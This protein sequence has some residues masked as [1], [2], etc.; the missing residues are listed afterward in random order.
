MPVEVEELPPE[1]KPSGIGQTYVPRDRDAPAVVLKEDVQRT[2]AQARAYI[3]AQHR[4]RSAPT[5][6]R[7]PAVRVAADLPAADEDTLVSRKSRKGLWVTITV[8]SLAIAGGVVF[9]LVRG[10][11]EVTEAAPPP[12]PEP[13][14]ADTVAPPPPVAAPATAPADPVPPTEESAAPAASDT[15]PAA[16]ATQAPAEPAATAAKRPQPV[17]ARTIKPRPTA[18]KPAG[19]AKPGGKPGGMI[20]R[21]N[22]F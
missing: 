8:F 13:I 18:P 20:V 1:S 16:A 17:A 11:S 6:A 4:A 3:E 14:A 10:P 2:E 9:F 15:P 12:K 22:P 7:M 5:I 21:D 19:T